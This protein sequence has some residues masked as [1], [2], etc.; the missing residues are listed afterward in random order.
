[1]V[2]VLTVAGRRSI[3]HVDL[4][5]GMLYRELLI[6]NAELWINNA[7]LWIGLRHALQ[8]RTAPESATGEPEPEKHTERETQRERER[9]RARRRERARE[10]S[11]CRD[12]EPELPILILSGSCAPLAGG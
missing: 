5:F 7:E 4:S 12:R 6:N 3:I 2:F 9:E 11:R 10:M 8:G 1:M